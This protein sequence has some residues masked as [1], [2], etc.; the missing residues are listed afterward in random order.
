MSP[1][2]PTAQPGGDVQKAISVAIDAT[3][4]GDYRGA[5]KL[6]NL[7]YEDKDPRTAPPKGL[8]YYGLCI[9]KAE[10]RKKEA[11][12]LGEIA[13]ER[14]FYDSHHWANLVR[15]YLGSGSR[16]RA[17]AVLQ[18]G[19]DRMP[20]DPVLLAVREEI[21]YRKGPAIGFLHRDNP[22]NIFLGK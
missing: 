9:L 2:L 22:I 20:K 3:D 10:R 17:V 6:F 8:S 5:L 7:I 16:R 4:R 15:I 21:G 19:L 14:E 11:I 13:R 18:E 1:N 12:Q